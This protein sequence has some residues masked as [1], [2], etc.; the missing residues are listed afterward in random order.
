MMDASDSLTYPS[1]VNDITGDTIAIGWPTDRGVRLPIHDKQKIWISF[2][3]QDAAYAF[4]GV[5]ES[6]EQHPIPQL[7]VR[8][9]GV[10]ERTQRR[11]YFRVR[12]AVSVDMI[13]TRPD[14]TAEKAA[15]VI[16][17]RT[18]TYDLSGSGIGV[19]GDTALPQGMT[20]E[21]KLTLPN[22]IPIIKAVAKVVHSEPVAGT[23]TANPIYHTGIYFLSISE[24]DRSRIIRHVF[25]IQQMIACA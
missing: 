6:R 14:S 5:V 9:T 2:V 3:R 16:H 25:R 15:E 13:G 19:R 7:I 10:P 24:H 18:H 17:L 4:G 23:T 22:E 20:L 11:Q 21:V 12:T 8:P 1:R